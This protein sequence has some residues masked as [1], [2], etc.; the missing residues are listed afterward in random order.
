MTSGGTK[1]LLLIRSPEGRDFFAAQEEGAA[2]RFEGATLDG[3][4]VIESRGS[5]GEGEE[6]EVGGEGGSEF[7]AKSNT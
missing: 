1:S 5:F 2:A 3:L 6:A 4:M 7:V